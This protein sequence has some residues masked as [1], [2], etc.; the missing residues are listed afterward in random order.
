[1]VKNKGGQPLLTNY[2]IHGISRI[3]FYPLT[4]YIVRYRRNVVY[5]NLA[6]VYPDK[7]E[8]SREMIEKNFYKNFSDTLTENIILSRISDNAMNNRVKW[9]NVSILKTLGD[10]ESA[11]CYMGHYGNWEW[12]V[13]SLSLHTDL[14]VYIIYYPLH[15]SHIDK[16]IFS[17][18]SCFGAIPVKSDE[19]SSLIDKLK[20]NNQ[21]GIFMALSDQLPKEKYVRHFHRFL[22]IKSKVIT[23]T[24]RLCRKYNLVPFFVDVDKTGTGSY[25]CTLEKLEINSDSEWPITDAYLDKLGIRIDQKPELWLWSHDR[26]RR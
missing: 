10:N 2:L 15:N 26:W 11:I 12:A 19:V 9:I 23:G 5:K 18:R 4:R 22:G 13:K 21:R 3:I 20:S 1:M 8:S 16:R 6:L 7:N 25:N 14:Q 17:A 24:E